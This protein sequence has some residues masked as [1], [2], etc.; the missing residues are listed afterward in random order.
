MSIP[1]GHSEGKN[2]ISTAEDLVRWL[3]SQLDAVP[4]V[5]E[6]RVQG[7]RQAI[8]E[9]RFERSAERIAEAML[10]GGLILNPA[11]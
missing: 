7:L 6:Q 9:G 8:R 11:T 3:R 2:Q 10:A 5:R 1:R 4:D